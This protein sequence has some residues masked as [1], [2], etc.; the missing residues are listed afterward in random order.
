MSTVHALDSSF[1]FIHVPAIRLSWSPRLQILL[2]VSLFSFHRAVFK[3]PTILSQAK[4]GASLYVFLKVCSPP[5][6]ALSLRQAGPPASVSELILPLLR[7]HF[8]TGTTA[9]SWLLRP[10]DFSSRQRAWWVFG[11]NAQPQPQLFYKGVSSPGVFCSRLGILQVL[12]R[13]R[14]C[15]QQLPSQAGHI[16]NID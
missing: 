10:P 3:V 2:I 6:F 1:R 16:L 11:C 9:N 12:W 8:S 15:S 14:S 4:G 13:R 5:G 7:A